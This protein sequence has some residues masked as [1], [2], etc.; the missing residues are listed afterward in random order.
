MYCHDVFLET[1]VMSEIIV[2]QNASYKYGNVII[3]GNGKGLHQATYHRNNQGIS[4][5]VRIANLH[6]ILSITQYIFSSSQ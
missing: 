6:Q 4:A 5:I 3:I 2:A 1:E